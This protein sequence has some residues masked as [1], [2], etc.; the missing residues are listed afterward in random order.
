MR[1][2][3]SRIHLAAEAL[4]QSRSLKLVRVRNAKTVGE[5]VRRK[6]PPAM[7]PAPTK[8]TVVKQLGASS[9]DI[10]CL[11]L[12]RLAILITSDAISIAVCS[13]LEAYIEGNHDL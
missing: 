5:R 8:R 13:S 9:S 3:T 4:F 12:I 10:R 2:R 1:K 6:Y 7:P 11:L